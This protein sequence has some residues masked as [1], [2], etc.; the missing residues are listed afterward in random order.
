MSQVM[1]SLAEGTFGLM[2]TFYKICWLGMEIQM[3]LRQEISI[4]LWEKQ[5]GL[6]PAEW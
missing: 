4:V 3:K 5:L 1:K 6:E 2:G